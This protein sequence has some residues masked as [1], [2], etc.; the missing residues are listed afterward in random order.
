MSHSRAI[1]C[2][3]VL[4]RSLA[5]RI[6]SVGRPSCMVTTGWLAKMKRARPGEPGENQ[7]GHHG[8]ERHPGKDFGRGDEMPVM[9]LR[10]H[11][12]IADRGQR[13]DREVK[14]S[15]RR[16][17]CDIGDWLVAEPIKKG[18]HRVEN[19]E[20]SRRRTEKHRPGDGH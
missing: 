5:M 15:K 17:A 2:E 18:E 7:S 13:L 14:K 12:A 1:A 3:I 8:E 6:I 20:N 4:L 11:V 16:I 19:D 10:V 9:G